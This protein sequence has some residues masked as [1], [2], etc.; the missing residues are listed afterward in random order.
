MGETTRTEPEVDNPIYADLV[1][2]RDYVRGV[3]GPLGAALDSSAA[4]MGSNEVWTGPTA[5]GWNQELAGRK[6]RLS[7]AAANLEA[8]VND[9][10][11]TVD[12]KIPASAARMIRKGLL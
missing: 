8:A 4:A 12:P 5:R 7:Q 1:R 11:A 3:A 10:L 9:K 2:L 6:S